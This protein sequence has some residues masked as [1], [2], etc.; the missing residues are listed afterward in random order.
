MLHVKKWVT[1]TLILTCLF[2][3]TE[4]LTSGISFVAGSLTRDLRT[5]LNTRFQKGSVD[6]ELQNTIRDNLYLRTVPVTTR[7][8]R[9]NEV[10]DLSHTETGRGHFHNPR[11]SET[12]VVEMLD[13]M[14]G[15]SSH[16]R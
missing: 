1:Q 6:H 3:P 2:H 7:A 9:A 11:H 8:P 4:Y 12:P 15:G 13:E 10:S 5:Y 14:E 16:R